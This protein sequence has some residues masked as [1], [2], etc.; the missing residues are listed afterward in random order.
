MG[1]RTDYQRE[2]MREWRER[3]KNNLPKPIPDR[4]S[5]V[6]ELIDV[7]LGDYKMTNKEIAECIGVY[8]YNIVNWKSGKFII[9]KE[10]F[11]RIQKMVAI[12]SGRDIRYRGQAFDILMGE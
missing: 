5:L 7:L 9:N 8:P 4:K 1:K 12:L 6:V 10:N 2:Y 3:K 11:E